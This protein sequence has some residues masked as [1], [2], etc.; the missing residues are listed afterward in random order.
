MKTTI[1][2]AALVALCLSVTT[3]AK[4]AEII[5]YAGEKVVYHLSSVDVD[6]VIY[7]ND[8]VI[9]VD[10]APNGSRVALVS[11]ACVITEIL[12]EEVK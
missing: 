11:V 12:E 2:M 5:C 6:D 9:V 4:E 3:Q 8:G 1:T 10:T 7:H